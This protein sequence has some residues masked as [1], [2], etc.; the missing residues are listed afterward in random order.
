VS[1]KSLRFSTEAILPSGDNCQYV[2]KILVIITAAG[3]SVVL[4]LPS[5]SRPGML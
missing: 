2:E 3:D 1:L 4:L 5:V